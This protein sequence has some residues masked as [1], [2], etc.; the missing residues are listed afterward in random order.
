MRTKQIT[1]TN[2]DEQI[3]KLYETAFPE[4]EQIPWTDLMRLIDQMHLDFT[5]YYEGEEFVGFTIV[6]PRP[7]FNW[8]WYFA[9]SPELRGRGLGQQILSNLIERYHG[10]TSVLDMES[11]RQPSENREIR[12]RRHNFYLRNGFR[13]TKLFRAWSGIEYTILIIGEGTFTMQDWDD[14]V[15]EL[16]QYWTWETKNTPTHRVRPAVRYAQE[17]MKKATLPLTEDDLAKA[18]DSGVKYGKGSPWH[19][20]GEQVPAPKR[21]NEQIVV[22]VELTTNTYDLDVIS[23]AEYQAYVSNKN[24]IG[25]PLYW[26]YLRRLLS[27]KI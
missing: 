2:A 18:F 8:F 4:E 11:T 7:S 25:K 9:V 1:A 21:T 3:R 16:R 5:A 14:V 12:F 24:C 6:Y 20:V 10:Q 22:A 27:G 23:C 26:A 17:Y 15:A 13:E 19:K